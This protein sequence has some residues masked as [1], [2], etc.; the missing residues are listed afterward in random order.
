[1]SRENL[2]LVRSMCEAF[3]ARDWKRANEPL[4][5]DI[6][7]DVT[8]VG[9][10]DSEHFR[11]ATGVQ[12]FFRRFLGTWAEYE[13]EFQDFADEGDDV[14][15]TVT[16]RG[17]GKGSGVPVERRWVQVWSVNDGKVVRFR[18][19]AD[20]DQALAAVRQQ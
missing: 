10:P 15:V 8:R 13:I 11:G 7:W 14:V 9:W 1:V 2:E 5:P 19:F 4:D 18:A 6:E 3:A 17:R 16:D 12:E 20:L